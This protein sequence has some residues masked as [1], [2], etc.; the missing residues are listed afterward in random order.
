MPINIPLTTAQQEAYKL[1]SLSLKL[2]GEN[3]GKHA[4][5][6]AR[7]CSSPSN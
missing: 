3:M 1:L 5:I 6:N 2:R 4:T 7:N